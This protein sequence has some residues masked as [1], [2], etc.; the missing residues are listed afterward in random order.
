MRDK[1]NRDAKLVKDRANKKIRDN[2]N[3]FKNE[4]INL[5]FELDSLLDNKIPGFM[6][7]G[8]RSN[9]PCLAG[10][11]N[12]NLMNWI[13]FKDSSVFISNQNV[14]FSSPEHY[15]S[16]N[17]LKN[18]EIAQS[19]DDD[20]GSRKSVN[21]NASLLYDDSS[22]E[23]IKNLFSSIKGKCKNLKNY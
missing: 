19:W 9:T 17:D 13:N 4:I 22:K 21:F 2:K 15:R 6:I 20:N 18:G 7:F 3:N 12:G 16:Y 8:K 1:A 14:T 5:R 10:Y 11:T 23:K